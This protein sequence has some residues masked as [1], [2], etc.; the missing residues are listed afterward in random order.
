MVRLAMRKGAGMVTT[1]TDRRTERTRAALMTAF[2]EV[3]LTDGYE[4][5]TVERVAE[6]ANVGRSTFYMHYTGKEDILRHAM[7][8]PSLP[9]ASLVGR[10][11][12]PA[13]LLPQLEH[14][15]GQRRRNGMFFAAPLRPV[16]VS[17]LAEM[18][19]PRLAAV[20]RHVRGR[21]VVPLALC[22]M[23]IAEAQIG[24]VAA[25]LGGRG[26]AKSEGVAEALVETTRAMVR[27]LLRAGPDAILRIPGERVVRL[28]TG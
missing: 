22:S 9:L 3:L 17:C 7:T 1:T 24:L 10:D 12:T 26:S 20:A 21:P 8:R 13:A 28:E 25:W 15:R 4:T 18:I 16:W 19:E 2:V 6:R 5:V 27:A 23:Q 14:F 11:I